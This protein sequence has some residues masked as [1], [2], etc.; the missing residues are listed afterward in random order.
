MKKY[1]E[2]WQHL[3]E[4]A[5]TKV[6]Q[7]KILKHITTPQTKQRLQWKIPIISTSFLAVLAL[8]MLSIIQSQTP[9]ISNTQASSTIQAIYTLPNDEIDTFKTKSSCMYFLQSCFFDEQQLASFQNQL[10]QANTINLIDKKQQPKAIQDVLIIYADG[11]QEQWK[12]LSYDTF[13]NMSTKQSVQL[14]ESFHLIVYPDYSDS[15]NKFSIA[16]QFCIILAHLSI[17]FVQK[18][19]P[20]I[21]RRFFAATVRHAIANA[22]ALVCIALIFTSIIF[23]TGSIHLMIVYSLF[24]LYSIM[25]I[26][27]RKKAGEPPLFLV[28]SAIVQLMFAI[29]MSLLILPI[30]YL[31]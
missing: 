17:W 3:Q 10:K 27:Y 26:Y 19:M 22:I 8:L 7:Q 12:E 23:I 11:S 24:T 9:P 6:Q 16:G 31:Y 14:N 21:Q 25:Q 2:A 30:W 13:Y 4:L 15:R 5:P 18:R 28:A 29:S 20:H 1:E